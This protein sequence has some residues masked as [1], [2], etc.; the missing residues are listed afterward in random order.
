MLCYSFCGYVPAETISIGLLLR[1][2]SCFV[3]R[4]LTN[5]MIFVLFTFNLNPHVLQYLSI[6]DSIVWY[7]IVTVNIIEVLVH[8][9]Y[10]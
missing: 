8:I 7:S 3:G 9:T 5:I 10:I 2:N 4:P 1:M 6:S